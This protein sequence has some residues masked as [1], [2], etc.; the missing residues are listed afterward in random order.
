MTAA[1]DLPKY[2]TGAQQMPKR[3]STLETAHVDMTDANHESSTG[4][5]MH[6]H[7]DHTIKATKGELLTQLVQEWHLPA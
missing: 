5:H 4:P 7:T 6:T 1:R 3:W 2:S